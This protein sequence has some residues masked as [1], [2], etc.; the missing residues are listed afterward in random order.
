MKNNKT[1]TIDNIDQLNSI[2]KKIRKIDKTNRYTIKIKESTIYGNIKFTY[3]NFDIIGINKVQLIGNKYSKQLNEDY[4]ENTT[5]RTASFKITGDNN[6]FKNLTI[7][8]SS[9]NPAKKGQQVALGIYGNNNQFINCTFKSTQDTLFIGPLPDDLVLRYLDFLPKD[10]VYKQGTCFSYF[11]NCFIQGTIDFI[12][13]AG[14]AYFNK[15]ILD[16]IE[17]MSFRPS[18]VTAPAHSLKDEFGFLFYKCK[19]TSSTIF[20]QRVYLAR[21]WRDFGKSVFIN[22]EYGTHIN[23]KGFTNWSNSSIRYLTARFYEYPK[24]NNRIEWSTQLDKIPS[25]YKE[26]I[27]KFK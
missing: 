14:D 17:D 2:C 10:E 3:S 27:K 16:S 9:L 13:G 15:C 19:F 11:K 21:P 18:Y 6:T 23:S 22:C 7:I 25:I 8:N 4:K 26:F 20:Q 12:F 1:Y 5:W 24:V